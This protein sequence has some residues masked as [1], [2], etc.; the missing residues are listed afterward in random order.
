MNNKLKLLVIAALAAGTLATT[1]NADFT[2][3]K[4]YTDGQFTDVPTTEWYA[5]SVKDAYEFGIMNGDSATIFNPNGT[6]TVAEGITIAARINETLTGKAIADV[7][8]G[9][10]Y[11]KYVNYAI[12]N[13]IMEEGQFDS[14]DADIQRFEIAE[15]LAAVSGNLPAVNSVSKLPD[16][17]LGA[18]YASAVLKLYNAG[19]LTGNDSYGTFSPYSNLLR[20]E[21]SAMAVRIADS[22]KRVQKSFDVVDARAFT[23]PYYIIENVWGSG[24]GWTYDNRFDLFNTDGS[25]T[26]YI[27]DSSD[28][29]FFA[30]NR[31]FDAESEGILRLEIGGSYASNDKGAY[32]ALENENEERILELTPA[33]GVWTLNGTNTVAT[34]VEISPGA[35]IYYAFVIE[36]DLDN[37]TAYAVINNVKSDAVSIK[38]DASV[39]RLVLGTNE[40]GKA[41]VQKDHTRMSKNYALD[42]NFFISSAQAGEAPVEWNVTGD[43]KLAEIKSVQGVDIYSV[44]AESKAGTVSTASRSF[45]PVTGKV[46]ME[47]YVLFPE[48]TDGASVAFTSAGNEI[49]KFE[50]KDGKLVMGDT[51]LHDYAR[52][53]WQWLYIEADVETGKA[54]VKVNGKERAAVDFNARVFDGVTVKYAPTADGVMWFD[55]VEVYNLI[56]H[57]D[58]PSYPQVAESKD[59]NVGINVCF[60]WRD[61]Q[62]GEGWDAVSPFPEF[63]T[64]LGF[65]DEGLR[66][67]AD[68]ELKWM[69][70]HGIDFMHV[71]WYCPTGNQKAPI[72]KMR[73]SHSALHDGYMNAKYSDLV[74]F[75][76]MWENNGGDAYNFEQFKEYIWAYW[77]E[78]YFSDDRYVRLDNKA[79]ITVW[80]LTNMKKTFGGTDEGVREAIAFMNAELQE[81]GYDGIIVLSAVQGATNHTTYQTLDEMGLDGT[82]GYHWSTRGYSADHQI[83]CNDTDA[84]AAEGYGHH[85]PTISIG[86]ND[87][88]RN[89]SRDPIITPADH[90]RVAEH[91]KE[92]LADKHT[93]TWKD[94]TVMIST[95]NEY[96]EG[97]YVMPTDELGFAY[98]ENVRKV[99]TNDT[100]DHTVLDSKPTKTQIDRVGH[101]YAPN[102]S[103]IR[104]FQFEAEDGVVAGGNVNAL[105]PVL[106]FDM[107]T[108]VAESWVVG[109]SISDLKV[110]N[111][112]LTGSS[113]ANDFCIQTI[114]G[115]TNNVDLTN[116]PILHLRMKSSEIGNFEIYFATKDE[117]SFSQS[118]YKLVNINEKDKFIDY[119]V[120]MTTVNTWKG[121][122]VKLR[123][124][125]NTKASKFEIALVE[126]MNFKQN[127][128]PEVEV[129]GTKLAFRFDPKVTA[130]GDLEVV[131]ETRKGFYSL[132]RL[133]F[134][135]DRF[136]E[137]GVLT[138]KDYNKHTYVLKIGSDKVAVDGVEKNL[139]FTFTLRDGLPVFHL[140]KFLDVLGY[141]YTSEGLTVKVQA[142]SD[143]E[144]EELNNI[145]DNQ[146]EFTGMT[147]VA[148]FTGQ[149]VSLSIM[150]DRLLGTANGGSADIAVMKTV[151]F[152]ATDYTHITIGIE[153]NN[154]ILSAKQTPELFFKTK[155]SN[156]WSAD[157]SFRI[158]SD[159][160]AELVKGKKAGD[161]IELTF[162]LSGNPAF[163]GTITGLRFDPYSAIENFKLDY[164]RCINDGTTSK[165]NEV[166]LVAAE[167]LSWE[168]D[169]DGETMKWTGQ[170]CS[171]DVKDGYANATVTA[172]DVAIIN[173][174][175]SF[176]T[177][178]AQIVVIGVKYDPNY[179][180]GSGQLFFRTDASTGWSA[181][182]CIDAKY[183]IP[184]FVNEGETVE[185]KFDLSRNDKFYGKVIGLRFDPH[186]GLFGYAVDYVRCFALPDYTPKEAPE[187][188]INKPTMPTE[189]VIKNADELPDGITI[190]SSYQSEVSVVDDPEV[191]NGKAFKVT[192][193][194]DGEQYTYLYVNMNFTAGK[195]YKVSYEIYPLENKNGEKFEDTIIGGNFVY[196]SD[197]SNVSNHTF[198]GNSNKSSGQGW[199]KV[200]TEVEVQENYNPSKSDHFEVWGKFSGGAG[201]NFLVKNI[202]I[203]LAD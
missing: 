34:T 125:P 92:M 154:A 140:K 143:K 120:N 185:I 38:P 201:V 129:N 63:D 127:A 108:D 56:D 193:V 101:M 93:G 110:E 194:K 7:A 81:M 71:C 102:H 11:A 135:W 84:K 109:H 136:T 59:Y 83:N 116:A 22:A 131:G 15:L 177:S 24:N 3:S 165:E 172:G 5:S 107:S 74:D 112:C 202:S 103:P 68:W 51:V 152:K 67:T 66:E 195:K 183:E 126:L 28:E 146:W 200:S 170:N 54:I 199:V 80:S 16:V 48:K 119:Y 160:L 182:K 87:V 168:F 117:P 118:K 115:A 188:V 31:D 203:T 64:Y 33:N 139:G 97:T 69:A 111:G 105:E 32:I 27:S 163:T 164:M 123:I 133:Y 198:D 73:V 197:G 186:G 167:N 14:Y 9:E 23:D 134:E 128:V 174:A 150:D 106:S 49:F 17:A 65:Y 79:L 52:N 88:G 138:L 30:F 130:D 191:K 18:D 13:G 45:T 157:K 58:Y 176:D 124:D 40:V 96:S 181:D 4:T 144:F 50:T 175:V 147:G 26:T 137:D 25:T 90:L 161:V 91:C 82:Y 99:F 142:C 179:C 6:L 148:G 44:Q 60:L 95:W 78:H 19:I 12:A 61:L 85:I 173:N 158:S 62:S 155:D 94:N 104:W 171:I 35:S 100:S 178:E 113:A 114:D 166:N 37:N 187:M 121:N 47:T 132:L 184:D 169:E 89:D 122:L 41:S 162:N 36:V 39:Q 20:S 2:K 70:E 77:K 8:G 153:C 180:N 151:N 98:L 189:A 43:F 190:S 42:E 159:V 76:I 10:W 29:Q 156:N 141:G 75:C 57:A 55:D 72:K 21:I 53:V 46:V 196:G 86:F 1:A 192:C 149:H 145:I